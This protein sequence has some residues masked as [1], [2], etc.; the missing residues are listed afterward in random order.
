MTVASIRGAS[1]VLLVAV[2]AC[3]SR[4]PL[5]SDGGGG[6]GAAG[7]GASTEIDGQ[8]AGSGQAGVSG[9]AAGA[10]G[11]TG[12]GGAD[13]GTTGAAGAVADGAAGV[14]GPAPGPFMLTSPLGKPDEQPAPT[15]SWTASEGAVSFE[16]EV[17]TTEAFAAGTTRR[18]PAVTGTSTFLP[19]AIPAAVV[20]FWRVTAVGPSG[21]RTIAANAPAWFATPF[22]EAHSPYGVA[23]TSTGKLVISEKT[24]PT[25]VWIRDLATA[26]SRF[27]ATVGGDSRLLVVAADGKRAYLNEL[28]GR[29]VYEIDLQGD[30]APAAVPATLGLPIY[31]FAI[32]PD[33]ATLVAPLL[34]STLSENVLA[35]IP[36]RGGAP[37]TF[38]LGFQQIPYAMALMP[39]GASAL[40]GIHGL[41]RVEL[42]TG[43]I[44]SIPNAGGDS[45]AITGDG[46]AVWSTAFTSGVSGV[47]LEANTLIPPIPFAAGTE[48]C[49]LAVTPD[50]KRAVVTGFM[51]IGVLD[52]AAGVVE[53]TY[54]IPGRCAAIAPDGKRAYVSTLPSSRGQV[55]A[56]KLPPN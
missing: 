11:A 56:L 29:R 7:T 30:A 14:M 44:T 9:A 12:A 32:T 40:V 39:D 53:K 16:V 55:V 18:L 19:Q 4:A 46:R 38:R 28:A 52:L 47:D 22:A 33:G 45:I 49:G 43:A 36:L 17:S 21:A 3:G 8:A 48:I 26:T 37:K 15:L 51:K 34:D 27:V 24:Q 41:M 35:L 25:G 5:V 31:G 23:V 2:T 54:D 42:A 1:L 13:A 10:A 20:H 50:G 6:R